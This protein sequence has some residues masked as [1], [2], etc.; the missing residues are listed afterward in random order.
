M[1]TTLSKENMDAMKALAKANM[2]ISD[3]KNILF[4]LQEDETIYLEVREK[5][6]LDKIQKAI[7][8]S[9]ALISEIKNNN[10]SVHEFCMTITEHSQF[11]NESYRK[12]QDLIEIF[13]K[14]NDLWDDNVRLQQ[15][16]IAM[17]RKS[18]END[19]KELDEQKDELKV[20]K[21]RLSEEKSL[22]ES[23]QQALQN[24]YKVEKELWDKLNS[25]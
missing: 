24:S 14:R 1:E 8:D 12:F 13:K 17:M 4:K 21:K 18:V 15:K 20:I 6:A 3:A 9:A 7:S 5:K 22:I 16:E 10:E 19:Q 2:D 11:L 23:R 25:K